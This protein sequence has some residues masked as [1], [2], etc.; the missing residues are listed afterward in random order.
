LFLAWRD[1][2]VLLNLD[3]MAEVKD[4]VFRLGYISVMSK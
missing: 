3:K 4:L 2:A 1:Y